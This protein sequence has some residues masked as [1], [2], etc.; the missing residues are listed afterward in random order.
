MTTPFG[1]QLIGETEKTLNAVLTR[2]LAGTG[3]D[4]RRW[5]TLRLASS[6]DG[7]ADPQR[8]ATAVAERAHFRDAADLVHDLTARGLLADARV[9]PAGRELIA[10]VQAAIASTTAPVWAGLPPDDVAA[11]ERLLNEIV[12][13][14]R[15][16]LG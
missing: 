10:D 5:V 4:E 15:A 13:R 9:T 8:L 1:P 12:A 2:C 14:A 3:L 11:T 6:L 7:G 16:V